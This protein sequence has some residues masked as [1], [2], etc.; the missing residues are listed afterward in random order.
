MHRRVVFLVAIMFNICLRFSV[1]QRKL[2]A[3]LDLDTSGV[4][5]SY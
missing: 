4:E 5:F 2:I 3:N 1:N